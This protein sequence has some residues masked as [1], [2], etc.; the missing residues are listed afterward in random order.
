MTL[1][2]IYQPARFELLE[3]ASAGAKGLKQPARELM[4]IKREMLD[5]NDHAA[6][7]VLDAC[8]MLFAAILSYEGALMTQRKAKRHDDAVTLV[9]ARIE[10]GRAEGVVCSLFYGPCAQLI[11]EAMN[12]APIA[13]NGLAKG[14]PKL[15]IIDRCQLAI[16]SR[17]KAAQ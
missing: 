14:S 1:P 16:A 2:T 12:R 4:P 3:I 5:M 10:A 9:Q 7:L 13:F 15:K 6:E 11:L 17:S 8:Y